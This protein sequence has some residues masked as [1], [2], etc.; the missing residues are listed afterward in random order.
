MGIARGLK[1]V[2]STELVAPL[3]QCRLVEH[4]RRHQVC[5]FGMMRLVAGEASDAGRTFAQRRVRTRHRMSFDRVIGGESLVQADVLPTLQLVE[6]QYHSPRN[7]RSSFSFIDFQPSAHVASHAQVLRWRQQL[8]RPVAD[9][10]GMTNDAVALRI[11]TMQNF[12]AR[13]LMASEAQFA[14]RRNEIDECGIFLVRH[15]VAGCTPHRDCGVHILSLAFV[16]VTLHAFG[17]IR[18]FSQGHRMFSGLR[19]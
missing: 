1:I 12:L 7:R 13:L 4:V 19:P 3:A 15:G 8:F 16:F 10:R 11:R 18:F 5:A 14:C 2:L 9:M 17:L 6:S